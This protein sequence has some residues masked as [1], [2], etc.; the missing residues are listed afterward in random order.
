MG[1]GF[2]PP[3]LEFM[4]VFTGSRMAFPGWEPA[5]DSPEE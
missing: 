5:L 4:P 3:R 2:W 1:Q